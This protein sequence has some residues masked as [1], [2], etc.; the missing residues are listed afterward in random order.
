MSQMQAQ[1]TTGLPLW[2]LPVIGLLAGAAHTAGWH[3]ISIPTVTLAITFGVLLILWIAISAAAGSKGAG[4]FAALVTGLL[5]LAASWALWL[6]LIFGI[7]GLQETLDFG[8]VAAVVDWIALYLDQFSATVSRRGQ[9]MS[10][11]GGEIRVMWMIMAAVWIVLP[12]VA[13]AFRKT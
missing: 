11:N 6:V 3:F 13:A 1:A 10:F 9:S 8:G 12:L 4:I 2:L 7:E 5:A